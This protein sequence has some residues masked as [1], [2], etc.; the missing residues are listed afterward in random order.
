MATPDLLDDYTKASFP[1]ETTF[2]CGQ[3]VRLYAAFGD[4]VVGA[5]YRTY[6]L[7]GETVEY[8]SQALDWDGQGRFG[9]PGTSYPS[10]D[11]APPPAKMADS[12]ARFEAEIAE[13]QA[14]LDANPDAPEVWRSADERIVRQL[15]DKIES[16]VGK[17]TALAA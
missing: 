12:I 10:M 14:R 11:L 2:S 8:L 16:L 5:S 7:D 9:R 13:A 3:K 15:S 4:R 1:Y 17:I 6:E